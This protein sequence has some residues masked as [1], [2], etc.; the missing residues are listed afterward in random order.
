MAQKF[1][2]NQ[3]VIL[4]AG[5]SSRFWPFNQ[6][7]KSLF[8]IKGRPLISYTIENLEKAGIKEIIIVQG[9]KREIE[10]ELR[11][12]LR[13]KSLLK[14]KFVIQ[15]IPRG[16]GDAIKTAEN[17][18]KEKFLVINGDDFYG[19]AEI[20]KCFYKFPCLLVK[21]IKT[22]S[23]LSMV[24]TEN[25]L[26]KG[27]IEKPKNPLSGLANIGCYFLP[28]TILKEKIKKSPRG[29]Y[30]ITDYIKKLAKKT[31]LYF[32]KI[33]HWIPLSFGWDLLNINQFLLKDITS[34]IRGK[35]EKNCQIKGKIFVGKNTLIKSGT[36][37]EGPIYIGENCQIGPN[38]YLKPNTYIANQCSIGSGVEIENSIISQGSKIESLS[39]I[40]DSVIGE[41][42][43]LGT[44]TILANL[45]FDEKNVHCLVKGKLIDT[46]R[47]KLGAFLGNKVKT[48]INCSLMPGVL[49]GSNSFIWPQSVVFENI[50]DN[51]IFYS[52]P[53]GIIMENK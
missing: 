25:G 27:I 13:T 44:G 6:K 21:E 30:E 52:K 43:H 22:P 32:A 36:Y 39:Y 42:C 1:F 15:K 5:K 19:P 47:K 12:Q 48:G 31:K 7:H 46:Q 3:A 9:P 14:I 26:V 53:Q 34:Q 35:V 4:A 18:L 29:E 45:R 33:N 16:T 11:D 20:K 38:C 8:Q 23:L 40:A 2:A 51:S 28:K 41:N 49:I 50:E 24:L 37:L 17:H 10:K